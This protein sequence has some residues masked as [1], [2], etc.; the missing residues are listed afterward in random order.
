M[1][2]QEPLGSIGTLH[3]IYQIRLQ[4]EQ[5]N[6]RLVRIARRKHDIPALSWTE[7]SLH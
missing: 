5:P 3:H 6:E 1:K 7:A 4:A 2:R